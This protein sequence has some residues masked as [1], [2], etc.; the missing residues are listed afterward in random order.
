MNVDDAV[1]SKHI[2]KYVFSIVRLLKLSDPKSKPA[3]ST[4]YNTF[5]EI[6]APAPNNTFYIPTVTCTNNNLLWF[7]TELMI[8]VAHRTDE[9][10]IFVFHQ[11][12]RLLYF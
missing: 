11:Y 4:A 3:H 5:A 8:T 9:I 6:T 10:K 2:A 1:D 7:T 12:D